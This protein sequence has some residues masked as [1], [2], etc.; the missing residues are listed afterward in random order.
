MRDAWRQAFLV[1]ALHEAA[2]AQPDARIML[3][4]DTSGS[5][6]WDTCGGPTR[7]SVDDTAEC[8]GS[9]VSCAT[10]NAVGCDNGLAD[11][12]RM[13][14]AKTVLRRIPGACDSRRV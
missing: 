11:D 3:L 7:D 1:V 6:M 4:V 12:S 2:I 9:D 10:C 5:M 14:K 13:W 8:P